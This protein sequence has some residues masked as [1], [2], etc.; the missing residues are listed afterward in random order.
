VPV[1]SALVTRN[2]VLSALLVVMPFSGMRVICVDAA[3]PADTDTRSDCEQMCA[4]HHLSGTGSTSNCTLSTDSSSLIVFA[5][6][7]AAVPEEPLSAPL[8]VSPVFTD[9]TQCCPE[10]ELAHRVPPPKPQVLR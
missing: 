7:V 6:T 1:H 4:R 3:A 9:S 10:P 8:V 5:S 2:L